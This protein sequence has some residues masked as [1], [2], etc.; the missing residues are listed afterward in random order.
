MATMNISITD[1]MRAWVEAKVAAG[2][3]ATASDC[4]RDLIRQRMDYEAK[5][6]S[7]REQVREGVESGPSDQS[8]QEIIGEARGRIARRKIAS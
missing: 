5:L 2:D 6:A 8:W 3:Y 1:A 7:L 4:L